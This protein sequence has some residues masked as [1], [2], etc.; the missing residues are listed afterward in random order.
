[1]RCVRLCSKS[2]LNNLHLETGAWSALGSRRVKR[3]GSLTVSKVNVKIV[4]FDV[5][6]CRQPWRS[7][8]PDQVLVRRPSHDGQA[9]QAGHLQVGTGGGGGQ[10]G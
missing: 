10:G 8:F 4:W 9:V 2:R 3:H 6:D 5:N 1:M 7:R